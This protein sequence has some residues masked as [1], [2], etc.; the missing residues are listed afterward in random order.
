MLNIILDMN[1]SPELA[2]ILVR[3]GYNPVHWS[4]VGKIDALDS[5]IFEY[6]IRND[7]VVFTHDLD[8]AVSLDI[9]EEEFDAFIDRFIYDFVEGN[10]L[11][12]GGGWNPKE[13]SA[14]FI[15]E[16]GVKRTNCY[17]YADKLKNWFEIEG[18]KPPEVY[19]IVDLWNDKEF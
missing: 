19:K 4:S 7:Y 5:E 9:S 3:E 16:I 18:I 11:Y 10:G 13:R 8:F 15:I 17:Y 12:C 1:L 2:D 14:S 6:A